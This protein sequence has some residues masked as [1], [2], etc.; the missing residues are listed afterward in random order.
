ML[1]LYL[2]LI[3]SLVVL[4][5]VFYLF[6][7][8]SKRK[9]LLSKA[10]E[11]LS[12]LDESKNRL[13]SIIGH[14]L[15]GPIG[16]SVYL[17]NELHTNDDTLSGENREV[18]ENIEQGLTQVQDLLENLLLWAKE[19]A[20]E[21]ELNRTDVNIS[22]VLSH[23]KKMLA[24]LAKINNME[25]KID[26]DSS[27]QWPVDKNAYSTII[28]NTMSNSLK[29][30]DKSTLVE[31]TATREGNE[32]VTRIIDRGE[33]IP[34]DIIQ[35]YLNSTTY[36]N[37]TSNGMGLFLVSLFIRKHGGSFSYHHANSR[38]CLEIRIPKN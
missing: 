37:T 28:R 11:K 30:G 6:Q 38:G 26:I 21:A 33:G 25:V 7:L 24:P 15:R 27:L 19:E 36:T 31:V 13:F 35:R 34:Q 4:A 9:A 17:L 10:N 32:L 14:D 5:V 16:N 22:D 29:Y 23:C 3:A 8:T 1:Y 12:K 2:S 20:S 18:I